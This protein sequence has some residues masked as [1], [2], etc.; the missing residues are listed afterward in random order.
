[1][2]RERAVAA[3]LDQMRR[4]ILEYYSKLT[5]GKEE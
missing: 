5:F 3:A 1:M 4:C 2:I